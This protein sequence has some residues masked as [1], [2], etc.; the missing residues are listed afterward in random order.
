VFRYS[1]NKDKKRENKKKITSFAHD[2]I[3]FC[4]SADLFGSIEKAAN[5]CLPAS[6]SQQDRKLDNFSMHTNHLPLLLQVHN[7]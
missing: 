4:F 6:S 7:Y 5:H 2:Y 3:F 1:I